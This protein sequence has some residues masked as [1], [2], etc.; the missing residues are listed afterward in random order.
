MTNNQITTLIDKAN[1]DWYLAKLKDN[2]SRIR[3]PV[4]KYALESRYY[5]L[6]KMGLPI[7]EIFKTITGSGIFQQS[8]AIP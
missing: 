5:H 7:N 8:I 6:K 2:L 1:E 3:S 4:A